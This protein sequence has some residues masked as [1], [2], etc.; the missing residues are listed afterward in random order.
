M[1]R[2]DALSLA[3]ALL[4]LVAPALAADV[5]G[6]ADHP[7]VP[8]Y[9]DAEIVAYAQEA[10]TDY[11]LL[12]EPAS[13]YGGK[14]KNLQHTRTLEG[15]VTRIRYRGPENRSTLEVF[16]NYEGALADAGFETVFSCAKAECGGRNFNHAVVPYDLLFGDYYAEQRYLAARKPGSGGSGDAYVALYVVLNKAGGGVNRNRPIIALDV[17]ELE[18]MEERMVVLD[19]EA[20]KGELGT[21]GFVNVYGILFDHDQA[22]LRADSAPQMAEIAGL[23]SAEPGLEVLIVG[24]TDATGGFD[25]NMD[26]SRRRAATVV[27]ALVAEH[28]IARARLTP[29]G[30]G[31]TA[32]VAT[33]QTDEGRSLN[34]RVVLVR[35]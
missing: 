12:V 25:Y 27:D 17:I 9:E 16:R 18:A 19:R 5:E 11:A 3:A 22:T 26:L 30:V 14:E 34:R 15:A 7:L 1:P 29:F 13:A 33:N 2:H 31:M 32:P 21:D 8:R 4:A 23:L 28:G 24:H 20:L 10:F 6:S 35:R